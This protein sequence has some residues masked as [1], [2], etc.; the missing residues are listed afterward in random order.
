MCTDTEIGRERTSHCDSPSVLS[1]LSAE[2]NEPDEETTDTE[3]GERDDITNQS[4]DVSALTQLV[5]LADNENS[6]TGKL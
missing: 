3:D 2:D 5:T 1:V 6:S 4:D